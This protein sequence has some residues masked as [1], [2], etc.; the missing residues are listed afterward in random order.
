MWFCSWQ[1]YQAFKFGM[2]LFKLYRYSLLLLMMSFIFLQERSDL[3]V[4]Y[5]RSALC[6]VTTWTNT[7]AA[8]LNLNQAWLKDWDANQ[9]LLV[10]VCPPTLMDQLDHHEE[11][12][13]CKF[14]K[15]HSWLMA[16]V[17]DR[18]MDQPELHI[19]PFWPPPGSND[20]YL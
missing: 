7:L 8:I 4:Q 16:W 3:Y 20:N 5:V 6:A 17:H 18:Q 2:D 13:S 11:S 1:W 15:W 19:L 10:M 9:H 14:P 12:D